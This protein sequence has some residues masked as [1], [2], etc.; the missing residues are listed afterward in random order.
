MVR[1]STETCIILRKTSWSLEFI[2]F[3]AIMTY[4]S[5]IAVLHDSWCSFSLSYNPLL[6]DLDICKSLFMRINHP[7]KNANELGPAWQNI[8]VKSDIHGQKEM[9]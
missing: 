3:R 9:V 7:A 8:A 1:S 6:R 5:H 4:I 2:A